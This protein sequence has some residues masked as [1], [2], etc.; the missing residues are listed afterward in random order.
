ML[1]AAIIFG[2]LGWALAIWLLIKPDRSQP[3]PSIE[4]HPGDRARRG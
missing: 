3:N 4:R 2:A 1:T